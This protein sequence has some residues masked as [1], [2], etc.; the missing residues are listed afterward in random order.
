M[1]GRL[2][3]FR[4]SK[5]DAWNSWYE[6]QMEE[7]VR[8]KY[9]YPNIHK[10]DVVVDAGASWGSYCLPAAVLG[11]ETYAFEPDTRILAD[12]IVNIKENKLDNIY[13]SHFGLSNSNRTVEWEEIKQMRLI[14]LDDYGL[15]RLDFLKLD[16]EGR[17]FEALQGAQQLI[18]K[19]RPKILV[20]VHLIYD[21][22]LL[23]KIATF[24]MTQADG[25]Q[26]STE[27]DPRNVSTVVSY[28]WF[29]PGYRGGPVHTI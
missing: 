10:G 14:K 11:A 13:A 6:F 2:V 7:E 23:Q 29:E 9:F 18:A 3:K 4:R 16:I 27:I 5:F 8:Q 25:Y 24:I 28:F 26:V 17:E 15:D 12:L 19:Y 22:N 21:L 20:E 1:P